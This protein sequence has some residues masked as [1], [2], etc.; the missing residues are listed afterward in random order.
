MP[1][2]LLIL[3][4]D[5]IIDDIFAPLSIDAYTLAIIADY[6]IFIRFRTFSFIFILILRH[7]SFRLLLALF[8]FSLR[9]AFQIILHYH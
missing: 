5:A 4:A 3:I 8:S 9:I 7:I 6:F 1:L 2:L